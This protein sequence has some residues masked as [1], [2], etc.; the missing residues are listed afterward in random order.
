M[1]G[2]DE[3]IELRKRG[4]RPYIVFLNDFPCNTG[5]LAGDHFTV[6]VSPDEQ[7]E[8]LDLRFL[9]GMR[10]SVLASSEKRA[11]RF[12]EACKDAGAVTIGVGAP[13][14]DAND[15]WDKRSYSEVWHG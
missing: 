14:V 6:S 7:P 11:R 8:W 2:Q 5:R 1:T 15:P 9:L 13:R 10:V 3:I 12:L 4:Q